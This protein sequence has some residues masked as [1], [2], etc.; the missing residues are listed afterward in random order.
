M[1]GHGGEETFAREQR[2]KFNVIWEP[3]DDD[4]A[5]REQEANIA[6][7]SRPGR[8]L[9]A[10]S[11]R[12]PNWQWLHDLPVS[13]VSLRIVVLINDENA[14]VGR[15]RGVE[16]NEVARI[17]GQEHE[18]VLGGVPEMKSVGHSRQSHVCGNDDRVAGGTQH[19][20]EL[21]GVSAIIEIEVEAQE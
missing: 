4:S 8:C 14:C 6:N 1:R 19:F 18:G 12:L 11:W 16:F 2:R 20:G 7:C 3:V 21:F 13:H 5:R 15:V 10:R 17:L 9:R